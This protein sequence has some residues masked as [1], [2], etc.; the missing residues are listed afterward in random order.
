MSAVQNGRLMVDTYQFRGSVALEVKVD[1][2]GRMVIPAALRRALGIGDDGG[3]VEVE[4]TPEGL[5]IHPQDVDAV[6][7]QRNADGL[8]V[9]DVGREV[10]NREVLDAIDEDRRQRG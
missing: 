7:V 1:G 10:T 9:I 5:V 3:V 6:D 8:L 2:A 4:D